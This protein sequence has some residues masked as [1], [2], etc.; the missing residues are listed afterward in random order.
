MT[1]IASKLSIVIRIINIITKCRTVALNGKVLEVSDGANLPDLTPMYQGPS[2]VLELP[3][4]S[5]GYYVFK[6]AK[7]KACM[8]SSQ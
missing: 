5:F 1:Y 2:S 7:A 6:D 8:N 3:A 4:L